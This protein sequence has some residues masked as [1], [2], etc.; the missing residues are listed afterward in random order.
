[1]ALHQIQIRY[2]PVEDRLLLR[3]STTAD[4]EF[5]FWMTRRFVDGL[6][7]ILVRMLEWDEAVRRQFDQETRRN[8][9]EIQHEGYAQ[10]GDFT[11]AFECARR[12]LPLGEAPVLL[13]QAKGKKAGEGLH[14]ISLHPQQGQ[15]IDLTLD[16]KLLHIFV[17]LLREAV[18]KAA[19]GMDLTLYKGGAQ[20]VPAA[21]A[22]PRKLN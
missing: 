20:P 12:R 4:E 7:G 8:V 9:L 5:R 19:W 16:T 11:K 6:W 14:L 3:V 15:G 10:Q 18:T 17:R 1:M 21:E 13:G 2:D 22:V